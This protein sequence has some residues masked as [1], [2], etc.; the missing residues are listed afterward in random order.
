MITSQNRDGMD[1][2]SKCPV[3]PDSSTSKLNGLS[4][5]LQSTPYIK[6]V[7]KIKHRNNTK[8]QIKDSIKSVFI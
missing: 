8:K 6:K 3:Y 2:T 7:S 5:L 4:C 1:T